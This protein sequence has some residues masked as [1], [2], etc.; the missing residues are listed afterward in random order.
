MSEQVK[1]LVAAIALIV[2]VALWNSRGG[3]SDSAD[4]SSTPAG[5]K[6][7]SAGK[8][9]K[10]A[11]TIEANDIPVVIESEAKPYPG[12]EFVR[13]R[14]LFD[15][16]QS[17]EE[18]AA[19]EEARRLLAEKQAIEAEERRIRDEEM[20]VLREAEAKER[21]ERE[22]KERAEREAYLAANPPKP[23]PPHFPYEYIGIIGPKADAHA[24][25]RGS[26]NKLSY[27]RA[28]DVVDSRFRVERVAKFVLDL[29]YTELQ[30]AGEISQVERSFEGAGGSAT[31][32]VGGP[33]GRR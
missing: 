3:G 9:A 5:G 7:A 18:L 28:G 21:A 29:T 16:A 24:I 13:E 26:G 33:A 4:A 2:A 25:L 6:T 32:S 17:P 1:T 15:Y 10:G 12:E 8:T 27:A 19:I 22:A 23:V 30:F 11:K 31:P 20:R 14:T